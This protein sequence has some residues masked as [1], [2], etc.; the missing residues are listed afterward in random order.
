M[1]LLQL[2]YK[3]LLTV[4][5][6]EGGRLSI[7]SQVVRVESV[8]TDGALFPTDLPHNACFV[9]IDGLKRTAT[10]VYNAFVPFW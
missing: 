4:V 6:T 1:C 9:V 8:T 10:V 5:K 3:Q 7:Q 2:M